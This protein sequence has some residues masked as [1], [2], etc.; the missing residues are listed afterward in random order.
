MIKIR[1]RVVRR[2]RL[3]SR[4][5]NVEKCLVSPSDR[6]LGGHYTPIEVVSARGGLDRARAYAFCA[7]LNEEEGAERSLE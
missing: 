7:R 2:G 5:Y 1:Y 4:K 6:E 3:R